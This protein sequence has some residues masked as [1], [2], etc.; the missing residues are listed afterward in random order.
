[1]IDRPARRFIQRSAADE[2]GSWLPNS[3]RAAR[4]AQQSVPDS[5]FLTLM[6]RAGLIQATADR[7]VN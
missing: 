4:P 7:S 6:Q 1:V 2:A 5:W 3:A